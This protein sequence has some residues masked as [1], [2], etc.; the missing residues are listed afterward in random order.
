MSIVITAA[1]VFSAIDT[2]HPVGSIQRGGG[3]EYVFTPVDASAPIT[4]ADFEAVTAAAEAFVAEVEK[5]P[6]ATSET[7]ALKKALARIAELEQRL[8]DAGVEPVDA[9]VAVREG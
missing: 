2:D 4:A 1:D 9:I 7:L 3:G 5:N 8:R 6:D